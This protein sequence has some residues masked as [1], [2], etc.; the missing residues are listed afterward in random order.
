MRFKTIILLLISGFGFYMAKAQRGIKEPFFT[1]TT[2]KTS[3]S[4][5]M[6]TLKTPDGKLFR[7]VGPKEAYNLFYI[8][9][10]S[11]TE[12]EVLQ[13][14]PTPFKTKSFSSVYAWDYQIE[15]RDL[16]NFVYILYIDQPPP[17]SDFTI[18]NRAVWDKYSGKTI[19]GMVK[20]P[21]Y[22]S[23]NNALMGF[24]LQSGD[25]EFRVDINTNEVSRLMKMV[26][27][28]DIVIIEV[29]H[30]SLNRSSSIP[31]LVPNT[32]T[33][34]GEKLMLRGTVQI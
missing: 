22:S 12:Q 9:G 14:D 6:T 27:P 30:A 10:K 3:K 17:L 20:G 7:S 33:K 24:M 15:G 29:S 23:Y 25:E 18:K 2:A 21:T 32:L 16:L 8:N 28:G 13:L 4:F 5:I 11:Y 34:D 19:T 1:K 26:K 31:V